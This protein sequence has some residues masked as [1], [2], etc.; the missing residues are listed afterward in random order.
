MDGIRRITCYCFDTPSCCYH[1]YG[2]AR[3]GRQQ[4]ES[5]RVLSHDLSKNVIIPNNY[6]NCEI[7]HFPIMIRSVFPM[8]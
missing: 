3:V 4:H 5:L 7:V 6:Y 1:S 2:E 8:R